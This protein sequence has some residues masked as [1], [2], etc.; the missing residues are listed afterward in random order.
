MILVTV[1]P[2]SSNHSLR[3]LYS[4]RLPRLRPTVNGTYLVPGKIAFCC[5]LP[6]RVAR[7]LRRSD[8]DF[9]PSNP[10]R[11]YSV[12]PVRAR[13]RIDAR[14]KGPMPYFLRL[15]NIAMLVRSIKSLSLIL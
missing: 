15:Y 5:T 13:V 3:G 7:R 11:R 4:N 9:K 6:V 2:Y 10:I 14:G 12:Q 1:K 8:I